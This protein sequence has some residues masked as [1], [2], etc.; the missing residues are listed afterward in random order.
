MDDR[1]THVTTEIIVEIG[2]SHEGSLGIA[3]S[4]VDM[5]SKSGAKIVKFQM[6]LAEFESSDKDE[7]RVKFSEQDIS[8]IEYWKR[9]SFSDNEWRILSDYC[10][11]K[12]VE[13]LCTPFSVEA[14]EKLLS[15][16]SIRRWKVGSGDALNFPLLLFLVTTNLPI[17]V[18]TGLVSWDEILLLREFLL[19]NNAWDRT[20]LLHCVSQYPTPLERSGLNLINELKSVS[21]RIGLSDH[22]GKLAPGIFALVNGLA[23]LE[24]HFTP[25]MQF[26]GPDVSSSLL[27]SDLQLLHQI[28]DDLVL[29]NS[30]PVSKEVQFIDSENTRRLFRKGIYWKEDLLA[31]TVVGLEHLAFLKPA[32]GIDASQFESIVGQTLKIDVR[33][34]EEVNYDCFSN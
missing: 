26:F 18:S 3:K 14:A 6:H 23:L 13:F 31:G 27:P 1:F 20:T 2:N 9:V 34:R 25:D 33:A 30:N 11:S 10:A 7:F 16:T 15:L 22:S 21:P 5:A 29:L 24:V 4:F 12:G 19:K 32:N 17:I 28:R 8:R